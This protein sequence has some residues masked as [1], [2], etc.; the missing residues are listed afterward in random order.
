MYGDVNGG[1]TGNDHTS[2]GR[3]SPSRSGAQ[4]RTRGR[5]ETGRPSAGSHPG[6]RALSLPE[7]V[8]FQLVNGSPIREFDL[9]FMSL[10]SRTG[11]DHHAITSGEGLRRKLVK[12]S[13]SRLTQSQMVMVQEE[14]NSLEQASLSK[15][16]IDEGWPRDLD[17]PQDASQDVA[18]GI[19]VVCSPM[20][21]SP[22][23]L[24]SRLTERSIEDEIP[25]VFCFQN[26][27]ASSARTVE[28]HWMDY[29]GQ[30]VFRKLLKPGESYMER[31]F[32]THP[33]LLHDVANDEFLLVRLGEYAS[34]AQLRYSLMWKSR[35]RSLSFMS[36][37]AVGTGG[38]R[39]GLLNPLDKD[40]R[41]ATPRQKREKGLAA[42]HVSNR[43][44]MMQQLQQ[45]HKNP[46]TQVEA[47]CTILV[48]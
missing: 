18:S 16:Q 47:D 30:A 33:W 23:G 29:D 7:V 21:R 5:G 24:G 36:Q 42:T 1:S 6:E 19:T 3:H 45:M 41:V 14:Q 39:D 48:L 15:S 40:E 12:G 4:Q 10:D 35:G 25:L 2:S 8:Q 32:A 34:T 9:Y 11:I 26:G 44:K 38:I 20:D 31:T 28:I 27:D 46:D 13:L 17:A 37:S 22:Q 43:A